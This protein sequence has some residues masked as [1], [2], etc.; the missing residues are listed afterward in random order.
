MDIDEII[1]FLD[2]FGISGIENNSILSNID[3][4]IDSST[5]KVISI[6]SVL[7]T[8]VKGINMIYGI[9]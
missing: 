8:S 2:F 4:N 6:S 7:G 9:C 3:L 5:N 1:D